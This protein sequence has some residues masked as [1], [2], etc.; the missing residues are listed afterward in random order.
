VVDKTAPAGS[1]DTRSLVLDVRDL[2]VVDDRGH[3]VVDGVTFDVRAGEI[4]A[5]AGVQG[6]GQTELVQA[7]TGLRAPVE[8]TVLLD[9]VDVT[10]ASPARIIDAGVAHVPEDR[11]RA[12][13]VGSFSVED[14]LVLNQVRRP[15]F[16]RAGGLMIDRGAVRRHATQ[17]VDDFDVRTPSTQAEAQTLSGG[18]QQKVI[19]AREL[20]LAQRLLILVQPTRG[21]DVGSIQYIHR[22][23]VERRDTGIAVLVVSTELDE[24][25]ALGDRIA[26]MYRGQIAD[27]LDRSE[28][29]RDVVGCLMA[30]IIPSAAEATIS[31]EGD[32]QEVVVT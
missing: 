32:D 4:V 6:N 9:G 7:I 22:Q 25:L 13:L 15:P 11:Q 3:A 8:G 5:L 18:N 10:G 1:N 20:T 29:H 14:N 19:V 28:A 31:L 21:L 2:R 23:I 27:V 17:L 16:A 24:V 30:G 12:G 26:V